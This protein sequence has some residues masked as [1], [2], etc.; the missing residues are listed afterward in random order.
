VPYIVVDVRLSAGSADDNQTTAGFI[1]LIVVANAV[2]V[3]SDNY[4]LRAQNRGG[5]LQKACLYTDFLV[6]VI[7]PDREDD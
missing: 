6:R 3:R 2:R 1:T 4:Y 5:D 7:L